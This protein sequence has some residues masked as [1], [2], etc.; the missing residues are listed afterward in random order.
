MILAQRMTVSLQEV[1]AAL[2]TT[3]DATTTDVT[4]AEVSPDKAEKRDQPL[5]RLKY[6]SEVSVEASSLRTLKRLSTSM[7]ISERL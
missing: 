4:E 5:S 7:A 2:P 1:E 3:N 6:M